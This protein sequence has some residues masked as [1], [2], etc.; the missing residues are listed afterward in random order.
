MPFTDAIEQYRNFDIDAYL[1]S[2]DRDKV[3]RVLAKERLSE[4]DFL[5]LLSDAAAGMLEQMAQRAH[6]LTRRHFGNVVQLFT[7]LYISN[8]C[9]NACLYCS[10]ARQ[11]HISRRHLTPSEIEAE[12]E[13]IAATGMRHILLL[14]G[15]SR[16]KA[17]PQYL[18][19]AVSVCRNHF[20]SIGIEVYPLAKEEYAALVEVGVDAL[21]LYQ[22]VYDRA[23]YDR[24]HTGG[25]KRDYEWRLSAPER[26]CEARMRA[27]SIGALLGLADCRSEAFHVALHLQYLQRTFPGVEVAVSLPRIRPLV[28]TF[29]IEHEVNDRR[30]VQLLT[31]LRIFYPT[32]GITVSTRESRRFRDAVLPM[33]VT[34]MS[35]GV[36]TAVGGRA[37]EGSTTQ[38]EIADT[39][40]V[41]RMRA[42][43][44]RMGYQPVMHDWHHSLG[45]KIAD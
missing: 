24:L 44:L 34:R 35:A 27:V 12:A 40:D 30:F 33:G 23:T 5:A 4:L 31:A 43:L 36:S 1:A 28:S 3:E 6:E 13:R 21:T 15:E 41:A 8:Y 26:A 32:A 25:P 14:T 19:E 2:I 20:S 22:E 11:Y 45:L 16:T 18:A 39:R 42:D 29:P 37:S 38:F 10:F 9:D 7:P 17:P